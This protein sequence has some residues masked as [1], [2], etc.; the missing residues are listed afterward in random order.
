MRFL[1]NPA[2]THEEIKSAGEYSLIV[3]CGVDPMLES[4]NMGRSV[5]FC[6]KLANSKTYISPEKLPPTSDSGY[7]HSLRTYR[8]VQEWLGF[9]LDP[10]LYGFQNWNNQLRPIMMT[11]PA[12]PD[13]LLDTIHCGCETGCITPSRCVCRKSNLLCT[14]ACSSCRGITC[15]NGALVDEENC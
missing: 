2:S 6:Q 15:T 13:R 5:K 1:K 3:L 10:L 9:E 7:Q 11:Q 12:A 8:Q 14:L 4:V